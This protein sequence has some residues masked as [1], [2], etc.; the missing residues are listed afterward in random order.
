MHIEEKFLENIKKKT[1]IKQGDRIIIAISGGQDSVVLL[2]LFQ[3]FKTELGITIALAHI[4][5]LLRGEDSQKDQDFVALLAEKYQLPCYILREDISEIAKENGWSLEEAGRIVR[6]NYLNTLLEEEGYDKIAVAHH[7]KDQG[8][9]ILFHLI[10]GSGTKGLRGMF[11]EKGEIIRPLLNIDKETIVAYSKN[12]DIE[13]RED[14]SNY[15]DTYTRNRIRLKLMPVLREYNPLI[16]Q[17]L[18]KLG[19]IVK[20]EDAFLSSYTEE[21]YK[22]LV[23]D[24]G[25]K[26]IIKKN[27]EAIPKAILRR[28]LLKAYEELSLKYLEFKYI[29]LCEEYLEGDMAKKLPL[30]NNL[31][32]Y[33]DKRENVFI[34]RKPFEARRS[35]EEN[36]HYLVVGDYGSYSFGSN[37]ISF[38][39]VTGQVAYRLRNSARGYVDKN[40]VKFPLSVR[41]LRADDS[42]LVAGDKGERSLRKLLASRGIGEAR[43][44][45]LPIVVDSS[46]KI[47]FVPYVGVSGYFLLEDGRSEIMAIDYQG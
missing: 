9:T 35:D 1:S 27:L 29:L 42:F 43:R 44:N 6:Y 20:E 22:K 3:K 12:M 15:S 31:V 10:R 26:L 47:V 34:L 17:Q 36:R 23:I 24:Q 7:L 16:E 13:Y 5:H 11:V 39:T 2:E 25:D 30:P 45:E 37:K 18:Y 28:I 41:N 33:Y 38:Q 4:N 19:E 14:L 32:F 46:R 8:E 21:L 40:K